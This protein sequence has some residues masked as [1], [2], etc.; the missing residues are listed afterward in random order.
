[1]SLKSLLV[2]VD[3]SE[4]SAAR[5]ETA[6]AMAEAHGAHLA[7]CAVLEQPA[8]YYGIG[9]EVAADVYLEDVERVRALAEEVAEKAEKRLAAAGH[10][11][12]VHRETGVPA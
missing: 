6:I 10:D 12:G 1:M 3:D 4:A 11:G 2:F 9:S 7:A 5:V 8:Y